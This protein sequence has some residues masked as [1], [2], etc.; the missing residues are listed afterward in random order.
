MENLHEG[1][2][3][4]TGGEHRAAFGLWTLPV[5]F[6]LKQVPRKTMGSTVRKCAASWG[7]IGAMKSSLQ[8]WRRAATLMVASRRGQGL[9]QGSSSSII[10]SCPGN[11]DYQVL[12]LQ[13]SGHSH[14]M[15]GASVFP[16][17]VLAEA[18]RAPDWLEVIRPHHGPPFFGLGPVK[19]PRGAPIPDQVAFRICA[20]R[21]TF[22]ECGILLLRPQPPSGTVESPPVWRLPQA[23]QPFLELAPWRAK[24]QKDPSQF[25]QL[26]RHLDCAPDIWA[27]QEWSNWLTPFLK[28][29]G[30]RFD[31]FFYVCC[32][33]GRPQTFPDMQEV[34][35][36][37]WL[38]PTEAIEKFTSKEIWLAPP[39]FYE[40]ARF[41][42][43]S[44]LSDLHRFSLDRALEGCERWMIITLSASDGIIQLLPGDELYPENTILE[45][46]NLSTKKKIEEIM[47]DAKKMHRI[48]LYERHRY[49]IHITIQAK[50]KHIH[51]QCKL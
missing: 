2:D 27:L 28:R 3:S 48:V 44:S 12:L 51:P 30:K 23:F 21:E 26:C 11:Q 29:E 35:S 18:D 32:L 20:I 33:E 1:I 49:N 10:S 5:I 13:R 19:Q 46:N 22:E 37:Q 41:C 7:P 34:V 24:I 8:Q 15:P 36:L 45:D 38:S 50:Y 31:T 14:F 43:F 6:L 4:S 17:G 47:K 16:G 40:L 9:P 39:Q 42:N 25:L